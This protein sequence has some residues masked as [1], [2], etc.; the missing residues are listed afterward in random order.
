MEKMIPIERIENRIYLIR[1]QK[2]MLDHDLADLYGIETKY[3]KRQVKRNMKRFPI[4]F[5]F[6]LTPLE[7]LRCQ[8]VTSNRGGS[9]YLSYAFTEQGV[10]MLSSVLNS[11]K[12]IEVNILIMRAFVKLRQMISS[13][14]ELA[15]QVEALEKRYA[16]HEVEITVMFK[17]LKKLM[18]PPGLEEKPRS[19]IG[20]LRG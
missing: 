19:R 18:G 2:V 3:L 1:G 10:A 5:M 12:A 14:K 9:R 8:K 6:Q 11:A 4:D 7:N 15:R 13:H 17:L 16:K 20:F